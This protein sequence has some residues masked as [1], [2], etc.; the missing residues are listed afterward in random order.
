MGE[1]LFDLS[2]S[3]IKL[4]NSYKRIFDIRCALSCPHPPPDDG[5]N[6][7]LKYPGL[8]VLTIRESGA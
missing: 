8:F 2:L 3:L 7:E 4:G 5:A 1:G 6:V